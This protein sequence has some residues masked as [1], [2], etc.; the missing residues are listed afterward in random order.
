VF[1]LDRFS[2]GAQQ[3]PSAVRRYSSLINV[4]P[5]NATRR[6]D[7]NKIAAADFGSFS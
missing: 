2:G 4:F 6:F 7:G 5:S 3:Y 1:G